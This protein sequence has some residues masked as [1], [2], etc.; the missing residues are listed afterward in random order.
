MTAPQRQLGL[1]KRPMGVFALQ[2]APE[3]AIAPAS[4]STASPIDTPSR[5]LAATKTAR[6]APE[7]DGARTVRVGL[8]LTPAV[9][10][11]AQEAMAEFGGR[12]AKA[13]RRRGAR[14]NS[15]NAFLTAVLAHAL[16]NLDKVDPAEIVNRMP[17]S[18]VKR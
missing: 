16:D 17:T 5:A 18:G 13:I 4:A 15:L 14:R 3:V 1:N 12:N 6:A 7:E 8:Y 2:P 11:M 10:D 9:A